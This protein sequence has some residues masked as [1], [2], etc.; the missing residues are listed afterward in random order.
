M[1][2]LKRTAGEGPKR[3]ELEQMRE[4]HV[5]Q[6]RVRMLG[7]LKHSQMRDVFNCSNAYIS[8]V[9]SSGTYFLKYLSYRGFLHRYC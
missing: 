1:T 6:D 9:F 4:R 2:K 8:P 3:V 5:L 7:A